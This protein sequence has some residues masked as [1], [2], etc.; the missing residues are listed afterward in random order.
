MRTCG[1]S[2]AAPWLLIALA[3]APAAA[4]STLTSNN[5]VEEGLFGG[6]IAGVPDINGDGRG[7]VVVGAPGETVGGLPGAGRVYVYSGING[8]RLYT[9]T[10]PTPVF[11]GAFGASVAG[12]PDVN[13]DGRGD[14]AVGAP[15]EHGGGIFASGKVYL[16]SGATGELLWTYISPGRRTGGNFGFS[17]AGVPDATGDG[18]GDIVVGA[19]GEN[20]PGTPLNSGRAYIFSGRSGGLWRVLNSPFAQAN[21]QF[22]Y[23]VGGIPDANLDNRGDVVVGA[24]REAPG[25]SPVN[26]GRAH[27]FSGNTGVRLYSVQSPGMAANGFF[28]E[29]VSGVDDANGDGRG[30]FVVGAPL[31]HPGASPLNCGRAYIYSGLN[32]ALW[33]KLLPPTPTVN[34]QFGICV[35]GVPDTNLDNRG[36]VVVGAW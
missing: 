5:Q 34:G 6:A 12:V 18:R 26:S 30:D 15:D 11:G 21:G 22:G 4:Q 9:L 10:S 29:S 23:S 3:A 32:G 16:Y 36:D 28:G 14:I 25:G 8:A 35:S 17:V 2:R 1:I 33:K 13:G 27:V 20:A 24:P 7:D 31:E 19:F